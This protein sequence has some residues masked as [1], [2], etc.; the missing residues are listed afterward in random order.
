MINKIRRTDRNQVEIVQEFRKHGAKVAILS[1]IGN[2]IPDLIVGF[3]APVFNNRVLWIEVKDGKQPLSKQQL[4][5]GQLKFFND[6][7]GMVVIIRCIQDVWNL[8]EEMRC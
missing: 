3:P 1:S 6:W 2:D 4:K 8:L 7:S 5:P